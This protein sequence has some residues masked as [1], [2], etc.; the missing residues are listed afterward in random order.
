[1]NTRSRARNGMAGHEE[2]EG[3]GD[4]HEQH[5]GGI[6]GNPLT[7]NPQG[8]R[9]NNQG[10]QGRGSF[11]APPPP[12]LIQLTPEALRQLVEDASAQ[13]ANRVVA[14][15][16]AEHGLPPDPR[17]TLTKVKFPL[18]LPKTASRGQE[19]SKKV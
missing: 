1:M 14:Q 15:Y 6:Q 19:V 16:A 10:E 7:H 17:I 9:M 11:G 2:L 12:H 13:A 8:E 18:W 4:N 5:V 3:G